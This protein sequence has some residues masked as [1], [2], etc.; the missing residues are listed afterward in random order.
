MNDKQ[1]VLDSKI[2]LNNNTEINIEI[3]NDNTGHWYDR[4]LYYTCRNIAS[5]EQKTHEEIAGILGVSV[6]EVVDFGAND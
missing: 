2:L 4:A 6:E 3:Q 1:I 5:I